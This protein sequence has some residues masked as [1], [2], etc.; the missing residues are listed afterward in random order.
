MDYRKITLTA[1]ERLIARNSFTDP[2]MSNEER[3]LL[4]ARNKS[5]MLSMRAQGLLN[6]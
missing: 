3:E 1:E 5:R 4:Y 2:R 6:E